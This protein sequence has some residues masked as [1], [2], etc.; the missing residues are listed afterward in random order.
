VIDAESLD[1]IQK[2]KRLDPKWNNKSMLFH[3]NVHKSVEVL[4]M[5]SL[6]IPFPVERYIQQCLAAIVVQRQ[7]PELRFEDERIR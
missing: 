5:V 1:V 4:P 3:P 6:E 7:L 2:W